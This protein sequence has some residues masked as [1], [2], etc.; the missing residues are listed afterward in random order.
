MSL[1]FIAEIGIN[2]NG[3]M[4]IAKKLIDAAADAGFHAVKFQKRDPDVCVPEHQKSVRRD[5]PWGEMTY[6]E[7]KY[8]VEF[9]KEQYQEIN[10]YCAAKNIQWSA[11]TWDL[12][13]H[14]FIRQFNVPFNKVGSAMLGNIPLLKEIAADKKRTFISTGMSTIEEI[15]RVVDI[16]RQA[17]CPFELMH[18]NSSYPMPEDDANLLCIP[19]LRERYQCEVGYSGHESSLIKLCVAAAAL[20]ATSFERHITLD[21]AMWGTDQAASI[22]ANSLRAFVDAVGAIPLALGTGQKIVTD[23]EL[24]VRKKLRQEVSAVEV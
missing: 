8:R 19:M 14:D 17:D 20:G 4:E 10:R 6:L 24:Q 9:N 5:T 2:H 3:S 12:G 16:F 22:S 23:T 11:S 21:R 1:F 18:C 13:S 15:D 7:Y